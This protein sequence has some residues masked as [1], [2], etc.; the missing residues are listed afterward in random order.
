MII[1][2]RVLYWF[3]RVSYRVTAWVRR[4]FTLPGLVIA[5]AVPLTLVMGIDSEHNVNYQVFPLLFF[6]L[7]IA[8]LFT[9]SFRA[10]LAARRDLPRFA[11]V[12]APL[13]YRVSVFNR[14]LRVQAGLTVLDNLANQLPSFAD[15]H[16][17]QAGV[18]RRMRSF[19]FEQ[20]QR[21]SPFQTVPIAEEPIPPIPP[22]EESQVTLKLVPARRGVLRF[23]DLLVARTDP[24]GLF[25]SFVRVPL[26]QSLLVLPRRYRVPPL[27][28]SGQLKYQQGGVA[29]ASS[30]GQSEEFM[31]L[32]DYRHGDPLRHIHWR[33]WARVGRPVVKE[34]EDEY[35]VRH[36]LILD[37][38]SGF[39][40]A[41][42]FEEAISVAAS[43][44]CSLQTQE[45]LLDLLFV[46]AKTY[47]FTS[48]RGLAHGD[49]MLEILASVRA[50]RE[51]PF[52]SLEAL[53]LQH[54]ACVSG[55]ICVFL[56]WDKPRRELVRKLRIMGVPVVVFLVVPRG[57]SR[58]PPD[59]VADEPW[60]FHVLEAGDIQRGLLALDK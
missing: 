6:A 30:V 57:G 51:K 47:C 44:A 43:F 32:R 23:Q 27:A 39:D 37:T 49:Q 22:G 5:A 26:P 7:C 46:G 60:N 20:K 58:P 34:F 14:T 24:L 25:R 4:R 48:G 17:V 2:Y 11:T 15:W 55:C 33:S 54:A 52:E 38:F 19:R 42:A 28:L 41:E 1:F 29:M 53:V 59:S 40:Q 3:Y 31:A 18:S 45:S 12:G 13:N 8:L 9:G 50:C 10:R 21:F 36:A 35:F 56:T 16:A